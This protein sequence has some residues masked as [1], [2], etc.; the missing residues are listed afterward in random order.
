MPGESYAYHTV[1][2]GAVRR[3]VRPYV[4]GA[5]SY[6]PRRPAQARYVRLRGL[7]YRVHC[8]GETGAEPL[9]M[10]HGWADT[11]LTFQFLIDAMC[12]SKRHVI[13]PDWRGFG[14]TDRAPAGYWFPDYLADLDA[15]LDVYAPGGPVDVVAHS[16]GGNIVTLYAGARPQRLRRIVNLEGFGLAPP[17]AEQAPHRYRQ[18]LDELRDPPRFRGYDTLEALVRQVMRQNPRTPP[19][20]AQFVAESWSRP[21]PGGGVELKADPNHK[22]INPILYRDEELAACMREILAPMLVA[23]GADS[24]ARPRFESEAAVR[25]RCL[26]H[27]EDVVVGEAGHMLHHD[28]P[29]VMAALVEGFL[30][31][32][33]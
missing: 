33:D 27:H 13:A 24:P 11:G 8:W 5:G 17:A 2:P 29:E 21:A 23:V 16:M 4:K 9:F 12:G 32:T 31:A 30:A 26:R 7:R 10:L 3:K 18:W 15:L 22:I 20:R 19:Q 1:F 28:Q 6:E 25:A 14:D